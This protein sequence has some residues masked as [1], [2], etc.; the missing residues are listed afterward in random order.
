[1]TG[2]KFGKSSTEQWRALVSE[3][4]HT[5][6][7]DLDEDLES[8]LVFLLMRFTSRPD[9]VMR[10]FALEYLRALRDTGRARSERLRDIGDQCLLSAGF[11]PQRSRRR[12][13]RTGYFVDLG[14]S[15][16]DEVA[17]TVP[18]SSAGLYRQLARSFI[19][20]MEVLQTMREFPAG[21][22]GMDVLAAFDL[23]NDT[24]SRRARRR[25]ASVTEGWPVRV[26]GEDG[27]RH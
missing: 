18:R 17:S 23:W 4:G 7:H 19:A 12:G 27:T 1:M 3:A 5:A 15:A 24:G 14:R 11:F 22:R 26:D 25:L 20:L 13:V 2:V 10:V 9:F 21:A 6:E 16:Y 8:Y